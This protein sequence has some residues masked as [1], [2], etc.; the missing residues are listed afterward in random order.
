MVMYKGKRYGYRDREDANFSELKGKTF[1][2]V[3]VI[4]EEEIH[5]INESEVF[6]MLHEQDCCESVYIEDICGDIS[7]LEGSEILLANE[8]NG[9]LPP[10][11]DNDLYGNTP[12]SYTWT[13]YTIST[14]KGSVTIRWYGSSN[15]C[16]SEKADLYRIK[17]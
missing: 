10:L 1:T 8:T 12:D 11:K 9:D 5:F 7:D 2:S 14:N 6:I 3:K 15:G 13:F 16:Y 4:G 17:L